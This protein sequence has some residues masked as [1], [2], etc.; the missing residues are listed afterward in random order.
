MARGPAPKPSAL[1]KAQGTYRPDRAPRNEPEPTDNP[2]VCPS[3]LSET[4]QAHFWEIADELDAMGIAYRADSG[5]L[6]IMA[7]AYAFKKEAADNLNNY[8]VLI[9][10][11]SAGEPVKNPSW[12][13]WREAAATYMAAAKE[14][15]LTPSSRTRIEA[16]EPK[17][18]DEF[19]EYLAKSPRT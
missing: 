6:A 14:F 5:T 16:P 10:G 15:G 2:L 12:Q 8:G 1:K 9:K 17:D 11:R 3:H 7:E 18:I 13:Q 4:A 19:A